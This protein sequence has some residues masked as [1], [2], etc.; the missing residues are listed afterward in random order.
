[1]EGH[2]GI[3]NSEAQ[4]LKS[5]DKNEELKPRI[6]NHEDKVP[7]QRNKEGSQEDINT[8]ITVGESEP[9]ELR[10]TFRT[11]IK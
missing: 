7:E 11:T 4:S 3:L 5:Y 8:V 9:E 6:T 10:P 2:T 1:M